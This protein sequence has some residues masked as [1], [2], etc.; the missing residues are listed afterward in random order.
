LQL[1][2]APADV[3]EIVTGCTDD[4]R[5]I[6]EDRGIAIEV[7]GPETLT[8]NV[9]ARRLSQIVLNL[10]DNAVKY[11]RDGGRVRVSTTNGP[12]GLTITVANTGPGIAAEYVPQLFGRFFRAGQHADA[13]GQGLGLSIARELAR[14]H[15][16][17]VV[18]VKSD[19]EW[20]IF[21]LRLPVEGKVGGQQ[22]AAMLQETA[23][24]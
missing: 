23:N 11:N 21:A 20:T 8:A 18:L 4:E 14:A 2:C 24:Y 7:E 15:G 6:A 16:G 22:A 3:A 5:I 1:D 10:L 9:D 13:P 17:D 19:A 12:D